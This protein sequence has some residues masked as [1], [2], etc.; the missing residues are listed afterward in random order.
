[1]RSV[2]KGS[3]A[4]FFEVRKNNILFVLCLALLSMNVMGVQA[5]DQVQHWK[6]VRELAIKH[7]CTVVG[8]LNANQGVTV[9]YAGEVHY[10]RDGGQS[11]P[12]AVNS[13]M[14]RFGLDIVN[15]KLAWN[16]GNGGH[17]RVSKDGGETWKEVTNFGDFE[18]E[19][20]RFLSFIDE[21]TGWIA[22]TWRLAVTT[23]GAKTW[24]EMDS[25]AGDQ[26]TA[27]IFLRT[28]NDGYMLDVTG[29]LYV[30]QDGCKTWSTRKLPLNGKKMLKYGA[31]AAAIQFSDADHGIVV[32]TLKASGIL[33]YT[34]DDG[35]K[36]WSK[37]V[38]AEK[39]NGF[40]NLS[41]DGKIL[42]VT[43]QVNQTNATVTVFGR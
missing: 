36:T 41:H 32:L 9:G 19:H 39:L 20:C 27:A 37:E 25:P 35:G 24:K 15:E 18:P 34:T 30:T 13:S 1:M 29:V 38:V 40:L 22:S 43:K 6:I 16:C 31:P 11:W 17:V 12:R 4:R 26:D 7:P 33:A 21:Q 5:A 10:T 8:F 42:T 14:C 3:K 28:P 2:K 23:D